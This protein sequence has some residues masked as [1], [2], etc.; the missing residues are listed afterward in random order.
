MSENE[1]TRQVMRGSQMQDAAIQVFPFH[2]SYSN[3]VNLWHTVMVRSIYCQ[4]YSQRIYIYYGHALIVVW[5]A[6]VSII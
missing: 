4:E 5:L 6:H 3:F 1:D 2:K